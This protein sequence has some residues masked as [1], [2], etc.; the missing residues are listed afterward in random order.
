[1]SEIHLYTKINSL[2]LDLKKEVSDFIDSLLKKKQIV[3]AKKQP[4]FGSA[5]GQFIV[6]PDFDE[7]LEDFNSI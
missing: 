5:K 2:P 3:S 7:P 4:I 6:A 1:M